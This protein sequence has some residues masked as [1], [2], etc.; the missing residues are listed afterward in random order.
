[1]PMKAISKSTTRVE[2]GRLQTNQIDMAL[3]LSHVLN[4]VSYLWYVNSDIFL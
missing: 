3:S 1:M 2:V 4:T